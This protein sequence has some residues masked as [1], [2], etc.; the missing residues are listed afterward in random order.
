MTLKVCG[1]V[2]VPLVYGDRFPEVRCKVTKQQTN[3]TYDTLTPYAKKW[4]MAA[5]IL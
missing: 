4:V 3:E 2:F 5:G 1:E